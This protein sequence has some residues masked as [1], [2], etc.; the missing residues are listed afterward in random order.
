MTENSYFTARIV[1][2]LGITPE[3]NKIKLTIDNDGQPHFIDADIFSPDDQD[4]IRILIYTLTRQAVKLPGK[5][6]NPLHSHK[7]T[8][9]HYITRLKEPVTY[10]DNEGRE[11]VRKYEIPKGAKTF[12]FFPPLLI[13]AFENK[14]TVNTLYLT[15]GYIKAFKASMHGLHCIGLSSISHYRDKDDFT[16]Y[17]DV[18]LFIRQCGVKNVVVLYDGDCLNISHNAIDNKTDLY[19]RPSAFISSATKIHELLKDYNNIEVYFAHINSKNVDGSPKGLD[20]LLC[21]VSG[22]EADV[23]NEMYE[24]SKPG[25]YVTKLNIT[26]APKR[27]PK[28]FA[29]DSIENFYATHSDVIQRRSFIFRGSHY[30]IDPENDIPVIDVPRDASDYF[31]VGDIYYRWVQ[32]PNKYRQIETHFHKRQKSTIIDDHGPKLIKHIPKYQAFCNVPDN[33]SYCQVLNNCFN[34]Y[35]KFDFEPEDGDCEITLSFLRHIFGNQFQL[36]LDYIQLLYQQPA[37]KLPILCLVSKENMTGKST[38]IKWV[39]YIF[40]NNAS[41]IGNEEISNSFNLSYATK[42]VTACEET[43]IDKKTVIERIKNLATADKIFVNRKGIDHSEIDFFGKFILASNNEDNFVYASSEDVRFWVHRI[44]KPAKDNPNLENELFDETPFFL[45]FLNQRK[46]T[47]TKQSRMW[48]TPVQLET[49]S[50]RLLKQRSRPDIEKELCFYLKNLFILTG[51]DII[52]LSTSNISEKLFKNK[53]PKNYV[54]KII[55]E[56]LKVDYL[57]TTNGEKICKRYEYKE[58]K[59]DEFGQMKEFINHDRGTP[60]VFKRE[61]FVNDNEDKIVIQ[62]DNDNSVINYSE[63]NDPAF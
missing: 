46:L 2:S 57:R 42:L 24:F 51:E 58:W 25:Y 41:I 30:S 34:V 27:L 33:V 59:T 50:L 43:F 20:D 56:N 37:Q 35:S 63:T 38:F 19:Q 9:L 48:F 1:E 45:H 60:F 47:T 26:S 21:A 8:G 55:T 28:Y 44:P 23:I 17:S 32:I 10:K 36:G 29:V 54:Q 11:H 6:K 3:L 39:K 31:R 15:E 18:V 53:Y 5:D 14:Q 40:K 52:L 12:P 61:E 16:M 4:N 22:K 49:E 62:D 13:N 7:D